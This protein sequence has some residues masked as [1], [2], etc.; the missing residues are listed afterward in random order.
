MPR[1]RGPAQQESQPSGPQSPTLKEWILPLDNKFRGQTGR[2]GGGAGRDMV[3]GGL[4]S[5]DAA[6]NP[7]GPAAPSEPMQTPQ[8]AG[9]APVDPSGHHHT[10][11]KHGS[12]A[13]PPKGRPRPSA[14]AAAGRGNLADFGPHHAQRQHGSTKI[15]PGRAGRHRDA[16]GTPRV[17]SHRPKE[18]IQ[19]ESQAHNGP[20]EPVQ[21]PSIG[22]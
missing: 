20:C 19:C 6:G 1:E 14:D 4:P 7:P 15:P 10:Q 12:T 9:T 13:T 3:G 11:H 17:S 2:V 5:T 8:P 21:A 16:M 18:R 22:E